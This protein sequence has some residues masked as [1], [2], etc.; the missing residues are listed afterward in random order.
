MFTLTDDTSV[1]SDKCNCQPRCI[2]NTYPLRISSA[3]LSEYARYDLKW[4]DD[5]REKLRYRT[6]QLWDMMAIY[7]INEAYGETFGNIVWYFHPVNIPY[8]V[9][10]V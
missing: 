8:T 5:R 1:F 3:P 2:R 9:D 4:N 7:E 10:F 6:G